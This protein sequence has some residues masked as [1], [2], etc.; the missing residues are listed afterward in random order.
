MNAIEQIDQNVFRLTT[1]YKD[2]Y[3]T[4]CIIKTDSGAMLFDAASWDSDAEEYLLPFLRGAGVGQEEL[5]YIFISHDH[6]DHSGGLKG[7][8]PHF[9]NAVVVSGSKRLH[10]LYPETHFITPADG[11]TLL[12][13]LRVV[14]IPGHTQDSAA[15]FD[16]RTGMLIS[17]D[18]LQL[19]GIFGSGNWGA[20]IRFPVEHISAVERLHDLPISRI[21][22][23]HDYHPL[24]HFYEGSEQVEKALHSCIAPLDRIKELLSLYPDEDDQQICARYNEGG[25]LPTLGAHVV[26][27]V[28]AADI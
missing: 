12:D 27:A 20:N 17:G 19:W 21:L 18:C 22:A 15:I 5:K 28:R 16:T 7:L 6:T 24:G 14:H 10:E 25:A 2:I 23:A 8:L 3:T 11:E 1:P 4:V 9:P 26:T 13:V